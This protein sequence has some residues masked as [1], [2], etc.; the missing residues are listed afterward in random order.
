MPAQFDML[1]LFPFSFVITCKILFLSDLVEACSSMQT[2][3]PL[4]Y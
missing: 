3:F 2:P 1:P 4:K